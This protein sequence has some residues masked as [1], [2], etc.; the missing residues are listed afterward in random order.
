MVMNPSQKGAAAEWA[1]IAE[2]IKLGVVVLRPLVEGCRYDLMFD[3]DGRLVRVQCKSAPRRDDV[4][5]VNARTSRHTPRGY[6]RT[7]YSAAEVDAIAA[8]CPE[9][10]RCYFIPIRDVRGRAMM[11]LRLSR[12]RNNQEFAITY[13]E[14]YEFSGAIAQLGER[15]SG[16][17]EVAGS[18]P[19]SS[20]GRKA[21]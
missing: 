2:A 15:V 18:S 10:D 17:H 21:A 9:V 1:I 13:A 3:I 12:A 11:H 19:A 14:Q 6:V 4:I 7:R 5:V 16:R 8:Y 20:T